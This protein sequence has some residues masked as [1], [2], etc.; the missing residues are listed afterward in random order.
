MAEPIINSSLITEEVIPAILD[1]FAPLITIFK[2]VGII[3]LI[4]ILF[5]ILKALLDW[6]ASHRIGKIERNVEEIN[7]K[8]S[9]LIAQLAPKESKKKEDIPKSEDKTKEESAKKKK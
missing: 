6:R 9:V 3:I 5:L 7:E 1:K 4:Y 2:A 8:L